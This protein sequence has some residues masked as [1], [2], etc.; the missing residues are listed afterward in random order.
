M[1]A[2]TFIC[3]KEQTMTANLKEKKVLMIIA[4]Q[5]FQDEEFGQPYNLLTR[6]GATVKIACS[7]KNKATGM[8]G[9]EV[10]P[11]LLIEECKVDDYDAVIFIGGAGA[12]EYF[13][14]QTAQALARAA[15]AKDKVLGAICIAPA[16]LANAGVLKGKRATSFPSEQGRLAAKGAQLV[17]QNVVVDGKLVTAVGP[18]A[19]RDFAEALVR[20]LQ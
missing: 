16:T 3:G 2:T 15:G 10:Q 8:F 6:L 18:Q 7:Q 13:D 19:A 11:D 9:R 5:G 12:S 20:L 17:K 4:A 1:A 14:N